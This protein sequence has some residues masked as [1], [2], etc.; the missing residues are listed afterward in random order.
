MAK[1]ISFNPSNYKKLGEVQISNKQDIENKVKKAHF[2]KE[3]W[4]DFGVIKRVELL[5]EIV[6]EFKK[7][8]ER[9]ALLE[10]QEMG[11]PISEALLDF[12]ATLDYAN[13]Y[14]ENDLCKPKSTLLY[15][16]TRYIL[17]L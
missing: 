12:D 15:N 7:N 13:W 2:A 4:K 10:A 6:A 14:F 5:R 17:S 9:F 1:L 8:K 16:V 11:M 3:A